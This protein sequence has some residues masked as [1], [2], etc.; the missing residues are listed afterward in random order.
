MYQLYERIVELKIGDTNISGL[1]IAFE[2]EKDICLEP[3]SCQIE[4]YNLSAQNR[5][6]L[7]RS[8]QVPVV[9]KAGYKNHTGILFYGDMTSCVHQKETTSCKTILNSGDGVKSLQTARI[10]KSFAK[11]TPVKTIIE[12]LVKQLKLPAGNISEQLTTLTQK[13]PRGCSIAGPVAQQ[14]Q[15][16]L[17]TYDLQFSI[18]NN[19]VQ[20][21]HSVK[22]PKGQAINLSAE[23]GLIATPEV[24]SDKQIQLKTVIMPELIPG[25]QIQVT[26]SVFSGFAMIT[27]VRFSGGNFG[28][29]WVSHVTGRITS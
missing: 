14:L 5:E 4:I 23:S 17:Q 11:G 6:I 3:N 16:F 7:S 9:L 27:S 8:Q 1:D 24:G 22:P 20:I 25:T 10:K 21:T 26:S 28:D 18:Q 19:Q 15:Q 13:L 2:I 12:E 29:N